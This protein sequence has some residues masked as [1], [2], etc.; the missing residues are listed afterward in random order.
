MSGA[1]SVIRGQVLQSAACQVRLTTRMSDPSMTEFRT[2]LLHSNLKCISIKKRSAA[3]SQQQL[4]L[5]LR[6]SAL[7]LE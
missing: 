7:A 3:A 1:S 5:A 4:L 6:P 2:R